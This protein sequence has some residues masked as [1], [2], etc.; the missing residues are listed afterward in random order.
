MRWFLVAVLSCVVVTEWPARADGAS[1]EAMA[2]AL[3]NEGKALAA[4]GDYARA[5][6]KFEAADRLTGWLGVELNLADC[7]TRVGRTASAWVIWRKAA[8]KAEAQHDERAS[9]ARARAEQ[10]EPMLARLSV[11][12]SGSVDAVTRVAVCSGTS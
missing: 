12:A 8:A 1:E 11:V 9:Y 3:F 4:A 5:C 10:L 6:A 7:Y 2:F